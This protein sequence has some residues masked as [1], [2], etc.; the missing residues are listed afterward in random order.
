MINFSQIFMRRPCF[1]I[2]PHS[3]SIFA[4]ILIFICLG[5]GTWQVQRKSEKEAL[6]ESLTQSQ[7]RTALNVDDVIPS[8]PFQPLTAE[9]H[10]IQGK[11]LFLQ[12]KTHQWK[13]GVYVLDV[14]HTK[15]GQFLLVQRGWSKTEMSN[16]PSGEL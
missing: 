9:G 11:T 14:F 16:P 3:F 13:R 2:L 5:L 1:S 7:K 4:L 15:K 8:I 10:F 6:I 12:S